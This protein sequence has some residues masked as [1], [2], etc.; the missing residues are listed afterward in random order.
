[1]NPSTFPTL[2]VSSARGRKAAPEHHRATTMIN[3]SQSVLFSICF[4]LLSP[5]IQN[6][7]EQNTK[8]SV[9]YLN[10]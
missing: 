10:D 7:K 9:I 2:Q 4:I 8:T 1:M 3:S 6:P 5:E